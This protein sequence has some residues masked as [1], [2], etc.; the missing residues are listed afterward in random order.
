MPWLYPECPTNLMLLSVDRTRPGFEGREPRRQMFPDGQL[1][2]PI[3]GYWPGPPESH[4][5]AQGSLLAQVLGMGH[6]AFQ[7]PPPSD[8]RHVP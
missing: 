2:L 5:Y 4:F 7:A 6:L 3:M 8:Y 1:S